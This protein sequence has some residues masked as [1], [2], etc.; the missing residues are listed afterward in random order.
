M[1]KKLIAITAVIVLT[2]GATS[3]AYADEYKKA[4]MNEPAISQIQTKEVKV[5][6]KGEDKDLK[7]M[8]RL[9]EKYGYE[10]LMDEVEQGNYEAM[11]EFMNNMTDEDYQNMIDIMKESGYEGMAE[12]MESIGRDEMID[13]HNSMGGAAG[14]HQTGETTT[15]MMG[16]NIY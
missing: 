6:D 5:K 10:D 8:Y 12:M 7:D 14:C 1:N 2:L 11:D 4:T 13:M 3:I 9:M 16:R 15:G